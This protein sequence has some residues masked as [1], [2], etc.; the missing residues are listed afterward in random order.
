MV[1]RPM[2]NAAPW[3]ILRLVA[4]L[5]CCAAPAWAQ[6]FSADLVSAGNGAAASVGKLRVLDDKVRIETSDFPGGFFISDSSKRVSYFVRP[7]ARVF[8]EVRQSNWLVSMFVPVDTS[9][10][11]CRQWRSMGGVAS[12]EN[13]EWGCEQSG[14]EMIGGRH[15]VRYRIG[16]SAD[17][18]MVGWV[19][20]GLKFPLKIQWK[21]GA[22]ANIE[23]VLEEPQPAQL[24][25]IPAGF[26]KFDPEALIKRIK[27]SDVWVQEP[28]P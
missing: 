19:D 25:E 18:E 5:A 4:L 11:P 22:T 1:I 3:R 10:D 28:Q 21:D 8:M 26:R 13:G 27:Q 2:K 6:Q 24:F 16:S 14:Q 23:N 12:A 20:P 15:V 17:R 9:S 7:D